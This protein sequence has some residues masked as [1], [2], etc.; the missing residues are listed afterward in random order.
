M[1][2][3]QLLAIFFLI[4]SLVFLQENYELLFIKGYK[5]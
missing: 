2:R 4:N 3:I 5:S 1:K